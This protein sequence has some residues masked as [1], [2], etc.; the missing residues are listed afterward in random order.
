VFEDDVVYAG[1]FYPVGLWL[2]PAT[3]LVRANESHASDAVA[4][5]VARLEAQGM[6]PIELAEDLQAAVLGIAMARLQDIASA[7]AVWSVDEPTARAAITEA[8]SGF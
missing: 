3:C 4:D 7:W 1:D 2:G 8:A 5:L 6:S